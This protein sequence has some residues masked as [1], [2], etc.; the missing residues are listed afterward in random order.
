MLFC[1]ISSYGVSL[2]W[3]AFPTYKN[4]NYSNWRKKLSI[5]SLFFGTFSYFES[6]CALELAAC[7]NIDKAS[8]I[9]KPIAR[10]TRPYLCL[11]LSF[12]QYPFAIHVILNISWIECWLV[13][14][15]SWV[16]CVRIII[17]SN[18]LVDTELSNRFML[19]RNLRMITAHRY[20]HLLEAIQV[21]SAKF[22]KLKSV[23]CKWKRQ[24]LIRFDFS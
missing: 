10:K 18:S 7:Q 17:I 14:I 20:L 5:V 24:L 21:V 11:L 22:V 15:K 6:P 3:W 13:E 16:S 4:F 12:L 23:H 8:F 19:Q 1:S 2:K 9:S